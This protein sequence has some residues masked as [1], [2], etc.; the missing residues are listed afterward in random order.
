MVAKDKSKFKMI[1]IT[2][3]QCSSK[4]KDIASLQQKKE[5]KKAIMIVVKLW[6]LSSSWAPLTVLIRYVNIR[7][8]CITKE[9]Q[10]I[11]PS[12]VEW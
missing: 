2:M 3:R 12:W 1:E 9:K 8:Y 7:Y 5:K 6:S 4:T 11:L 10:L